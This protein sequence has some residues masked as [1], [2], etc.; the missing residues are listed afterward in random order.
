LVQGRLAHLRPRVQLRFRRGHHGAADFGELGLCEIQRSL[1]KEF[2]YGIPTWVVQ[3][4][5]V[6][7][8]PS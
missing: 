5:I 6:I 7:G 4:L 1:G 2:A 3:L 8:S